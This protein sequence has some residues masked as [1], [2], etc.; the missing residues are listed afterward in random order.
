[1]ASSEIEFVDH[2]KIP[3]SDYQRAIN[4]SIDKL[5]AFSEFAELVQFL[6]KCS[7]ASFNM[8]ALNTK[9][10]KGIDEL[11]AKTVNVFFNIPDAAK[12][13]KDFDEKFSEICEENN[14]NCGHLAKDEVK[15]NAYQYVK[16]YID[17]SININAA[18]SQSKTAMT[19]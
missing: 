9:Y 14:I 7:I 1:M 18:L 17:Q 13:D 15:Q 8:H 10:G 4:S 19:R 5:S 11:A 2:N 16:E 3:H 12:T 6:Q